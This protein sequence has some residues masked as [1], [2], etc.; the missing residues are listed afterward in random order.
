MRTTSIVATI[1]IIASTVYGK[2]KFFDEEFIPNKNNELINMIVDTYM[3]GVLTE[4]NEKELDFERLQEKL[5][6]HIEN[7]PALQ[8]V[9]LWVRKRPPTGNIDDL[10]KPEVD[11]IWHKKINRNE[12][13]YFEDILL[14]KKSLFPSEEICQTKRKWEMINSTLDIYGHEVDI[15]HDEYVQYVFTY[16]CADPGS[17][18]IGISNIYNSE[19]EERK[20]WMYLLNRESSN[21]KARPVWSPVAVPHHCACK[22]TR[23]IF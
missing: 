10:R 16:R 14:H 4:N 12:P 23:K 15:L 20:A 8:Q 13:E 21:E 17:S 19:C 5:V 1:F 7:H 3:D 11:S 9:G 18:C 22:L 6:R 2:R